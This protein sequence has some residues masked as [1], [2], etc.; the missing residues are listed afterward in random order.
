MLKHPQLALLGQRIRA[1][2]KA[3]G[4]SQEVFSLEAEIARTYYGE[5]ERG[6]RNIAAL[7]LI[8]IADELGVEVG[9]LFPSLHELRKAGGGRK[10]KG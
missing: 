7:N 2:R 6:Q 1:L 3:K 8:R 10:L 5:V 9:E 4:F